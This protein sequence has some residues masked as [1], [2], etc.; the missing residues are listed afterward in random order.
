MKRNDPNNKIIKNRPNI[1]E[2]NIATKQVLRGLKYVPK[3]TSSSSAKG[4]LNIIQY[5]AP[6]T[7]V[8]ARY[9]PVSTSK[10]NP[11]KPNKVNKISLINNLSRER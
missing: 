3:N 6:A 8:K 11:I 5:K 9:R 10:L 7:Y 2:P 4:I 1:I